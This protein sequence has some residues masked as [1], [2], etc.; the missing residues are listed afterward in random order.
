[1]LLLLHEEIHKRR[2]SKLPDVN[3]K[4]K[5]IKKTWMER[6]IHSSLL[7]A[8]KQMSNKK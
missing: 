4:N 3:N 7:E 5:I 6:G 8:K 2:G 1:M